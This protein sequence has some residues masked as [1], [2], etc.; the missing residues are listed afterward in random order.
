[1]KKIPGLLII[2]ALLIV[3]A[4]TSVE[5]EKNTLDRPEP[6][7]PIS[8][9][10]KGA[11][12]VV[13]ITE[14]SYYEEVAEGTKHCLTLKTSGWMYIYR[15]DGTVLDYA[16]PFAITKVAPHNGDGSRTAK[17]IKNLATKYGVTVQFANV[18]FLGRSGCDPKGFYNSI[19]GSYASSAKHPG[20]GLVRLGTGKYK[21]CISKYSAKNIDMALH[22]MAHPIMEAKCEGRNVYREEHTTDAYAYRYLNA[23]S[24]NP[25]NYGFN[26]RDYARAR[27]V[28]LGNC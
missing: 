6:S 28:R 5:D 27:H 18:D 10:V 17:H 19:S 25:G 23:A 26:A 15:P 13:W 12:S 21:S 14:P 16:S 8:E 22:E 9:T 24:R 20:E 2:M 3:L 4:L 11:C 1:M 7:A